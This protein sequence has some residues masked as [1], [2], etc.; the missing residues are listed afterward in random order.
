MTAELAAEKPQGLTIWTYRRRFR[1]DRK[2]KG[3]VLFKAGFGGLL[4]ILVIDGEERARDFTPVAGPDAVRNHRLV[5]RLDDGRL[6][7]IEAGY[8]S[9]WSVGIRASLDGALF[10]ESHKGRTIAFP[11]RLK[12]AVTQ[13][14]AGGDPAIDFSKFKKNRVAIGV[15]IAL[16]LLFFIVAKMTDLKTAALVSAAAGLLLVVAQRFVKNVDLLGGLALFGIVMMLISAGFAIMF[17][18]EDI[19][20]LRSTIVGLIGASLFL[21]DGLFGGRYL[22]ERLSRY[23][24][25]ADLERRRLSIAIGLV[26]AIVALV[27]WAVAAWAST[28]VWLFYSTFLDI[29]VAVALFMIG[30]NWARGRGLKFA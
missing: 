1:I 24:V 14:T 28:D 7:E 4:T 20:K 19:I 22:G 29:V 8:I 11:A 6:L 25:Y 27:N 9:W 15:D 30:I 13:Q 12:S 5:A 18:D 2:Q 23:L 26:G 21:T 17:D 3:L 16:G 10:H